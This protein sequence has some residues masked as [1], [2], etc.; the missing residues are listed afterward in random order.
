MGFIDILVLSSF[1]ALFIGH[2][3]EI[4]FQ[5]HYNRNGLW[6]IFKISIDPTILLLCALYFRNELL[7]T[8]LGSWALFGLCAEFLIHIVHF[9]FI[10]DSSIGPY[11]DGVR[12]LWYSLL[13]NAIDIIV[14]TSA[15]YPIS[16]MFD[17]QALVTALILGTVQV[18][19]M[20]RFS[21]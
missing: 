7:M 8:S 3:Y 4:L 12:P 1:Y 11:K 17:Q 2:I 19:T 9:V 15:M 21:D 13:F 14:I 16:H 6:F 5:N 10:F 20:Y 18:L